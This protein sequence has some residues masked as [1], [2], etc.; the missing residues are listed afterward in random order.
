MVLLLVFGGACGCSRGG[1]C[2][3]S[4]G[5]IIEL[6]LLLAWLLLVLFGGHAWLL[7][8]VAPGGACVV[9]SMLERAVRI[10]SFFKN[11]F[12][13]EQLLVAHRATFFE[14]KTCFTFLF[15]QKHLQH[16][17]I[18]VAHRGTLLL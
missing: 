15:F 7:S 10:T 3:C 12:S 4:W 2:G 18:L 16:C 11:I 14:A 17:A 1:V 9:S 6:W 5:D 8:M 13:T